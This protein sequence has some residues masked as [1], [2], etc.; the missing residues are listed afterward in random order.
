MCIDLVLW[1]ASQLPDLIRV[2]LAYH[3][4]HTL[5]LESSRE[6]R[7]HQFSTVALFVNLLELAE[8][9]ILHQL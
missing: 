7:W 5:R 1:L 2:Q 4:G 9:G 3:G 6:G 8:Q